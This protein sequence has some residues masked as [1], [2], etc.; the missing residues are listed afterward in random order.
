M[1]FAG[2]VSGIGSIVQ[3]Q[4][5][6]PFLSKVQAPPPRFQIS[7]R[8]WSL[9]G[10]NCE[11]K[12]NRSRHNHSTQHSSQKYASHFVLEHPNFVAFVHSSHLLLRQLHCQVLED[13]RNSAR[14]SFGAIGNLRSGST[15]QRVNVLTKH[16]G[17]L[18]EPARS[19]PRPA[20]H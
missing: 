20:M 13:G 3:A 1:R 11:N 10:R 14:F 2:R 18:C 19:P 8:Q 5:M 9:F 17:F 15:I 7:I 4:L 6:W 16:V 12:C